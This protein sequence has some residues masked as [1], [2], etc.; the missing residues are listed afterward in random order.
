[1]YLRIYCCTQKHV[2]YLYLRQLAVKNTQLGREINFIIAFQFGGFCFV[3]S[4]VMN[5]N[6]LFL[7]LHLVFC[8]ISNTV[9]VI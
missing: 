7:Q 5:R 3:V 8:R 2:M 9:K 4:K 6:I 1:M